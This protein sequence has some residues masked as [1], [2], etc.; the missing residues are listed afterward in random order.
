M[1]NPHHRMSIISP[2]AHIR[3]YNI[4]SFLILMVTG[5]LLSFLGGYTNATCIVSTWKASIT[6]FTGTSSRVGA[7][8]AQRNIETAL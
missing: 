1:A 4:R 2:A 6:G 5:C 7:G 8:L 3:S